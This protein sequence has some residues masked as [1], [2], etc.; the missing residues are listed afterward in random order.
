MSSPND[1][2]SAG[3]WVHVS[4]VRHGQT[5][6]N[7]KKV[8][9][10]H[11][12]VPLNDR[13]RM[14]A[15]LLR[16]R[17]AAE[18]EFASSPVFTSDLLRAADTALV[19]FCPEGNDRSPDQLITSEFFRERHLGSLQGQSY[20]T[21]VNTIQEK[22]GIEYHNTPPPKSISFWDRVAHACP[23]LDVECGYTF[24]SRADSALEYVL[25]HPEVTWS[26]DT[27][28]V[29]VS[30]GLMILAMLSRLMLRSTTTDVLQP[31]E[32]HE[33]H[34]RPH[35]WIVLGNG[36]GRLGNTSIST[37]RMWRG[38]DGVYS[39]TS[40]VRSNDVAHAESL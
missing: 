31:S 11:M 14:E 38:T 30:H 6:H 2:G 15:Q 3:C 9:Q 4:F 40:L 12:D 35:R 20:H 22:A 37:V 39:Q 28:A 17:V 21:M 19:A 27:H 32:P 24:S 36:D 7:L 13:G 25:T 29:V 34:E 33:A 5:D 1:D 26:G 8:I 16:D 23:D 10:G 18:G